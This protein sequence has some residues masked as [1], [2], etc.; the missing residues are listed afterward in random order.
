MTA[1]CKRSLNILF[2][3]FCTSVASEDLSG[4]MLQH[5]KHCINKCHGLDLTTENPMYIDKAYSEK[6]AEMQREMT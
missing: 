4:V 2:Q 3:L 6:E 5:A 1:L